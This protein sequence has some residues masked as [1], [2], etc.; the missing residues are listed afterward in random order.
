MTLFDFETGGFG[1]LS[2]CEMLDCVN[3]S[4]LLTVRVCS[5]V[6]GTC[7]V[8]CFGVQLVSLCSYSR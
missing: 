4:G 5:V 1:N 2:C 7:H 8:Q 6:R 3:V